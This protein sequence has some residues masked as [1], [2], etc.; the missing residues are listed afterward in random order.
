[1]L[2]RVNQRE[3]LF[4][5]ITKKADAGLKSYIA[6]EAAPVTTKTSTRKPKPGAIIVPPARLLV[7]V[8]RDRGGPRRRCKFETGV[9]TLVERPSLADLVICGAFGDLDGDFAV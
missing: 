7:E 3:W 8:C 1:M 5:G 9:G 4:D 2:Q 6:V